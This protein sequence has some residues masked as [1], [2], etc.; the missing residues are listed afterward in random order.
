MPSHL[1]RRQFD[2]ALKAVCVTI[3]GPRAL[4]AFIFG[5]LPGFPL[6]LALH[7]AFTAAHAQKTLRACRMHPARGTNSGL[8]ACYVTAGL[9]GCICHGFVIVAGSNFHRLPHVRHTHIATGSPS[10]AA[11]WT[12]STSPHAGH[13]GGKRCRRARRIISSFWR[14]VSLIY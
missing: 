13:A 10:H 12:C 9:G 14:I 4:A 5:L 8:A 7:G 3:S 1:L 6:R 2:A 11:S